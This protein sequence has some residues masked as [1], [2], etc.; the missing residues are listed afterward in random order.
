VDQK[1]LKQHPVDLKDL[2]DLLG[3]E[4]SMHFPEYLVGLVDQ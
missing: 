1:L 2:E 4:Q 3:R